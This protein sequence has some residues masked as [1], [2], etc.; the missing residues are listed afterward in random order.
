[1]SKR[2]RTSKSNKNKIPKVSS[3]ISQ[4]QQDS[5]HHQIYSF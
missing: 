1:M 5:N 3:F 4:P 2:A